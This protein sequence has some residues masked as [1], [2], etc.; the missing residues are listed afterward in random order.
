MVDINECQDLHICG[1]ADAICYNTFG[2]FACVCHDPMKEYVGGECV[3]RDVCNGDEGI[4]NPCD[5]DNGICVNTLEGPQCFCKE[6]YRLGS[7]GVRCEGAKHV[8][9]THKLSFRSKRMF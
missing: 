2:S 9:S 1:G 3:L 5:R 7:D 4:S 8:L 6:G